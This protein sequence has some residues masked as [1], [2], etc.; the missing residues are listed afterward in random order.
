MG[1]E[2][3]AMASDGANV[4]SARFFHGNDAVSCAALTPDFTLV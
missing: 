3:P 4:P 1:T 2:A